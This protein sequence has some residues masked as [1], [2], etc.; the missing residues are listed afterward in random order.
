MV[1]GGIK[2]FFILPRS[3]SVHPEIEKS[4][5]WNYFANSMDN[6]FWFFGESLAAY[7]TIIP[8]YFSNFTTSP[9]LIG[10]I[11]AIR[12][13]GWFLPQLFLAPFVERLDRKMPTLTRLALLERLPFLALAVAALWLPTLEKNL[14]VIIFLG[15]WIW[16]SISSGFTALPWQELIAKVIP[17]SHR[18]RYFGFANLIGSFT[19]VVGASLAGVILSR[20]LYPRNYALSF[21]LAFIGVMISYFFLL[22]NRE[23]AIKENIELVTRSKPYKGKITKVLAED[24]NFR[25]FLISRSLNYFGWMAYGFIAVFAITHFNLPPAYS[26]RFAAIISATSIFGYL[27]WGIA[28]DR[29]GHKRV[30]L[31]ADLIWAIGLAILFL[32]P[33]ITTVYLVFSLIG[34]ATTGDVVGDLN[35]AMEFGQIEDRPTYIGMARTLTSPI[36]LLAPIV[37]GLI[38]KVYDYHIMVGASLVFALLGVIFLGTQVIEPRH[39]SKS[40]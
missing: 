7:N 27:V 8:V 36:L 22:Q 25:T 20:I 2:R 30:V 32:S 21:S 12:D 5:K 19:R 34:F 10:L 16:K 29:Y 6:I 13:T 37:G 33:S 3:I 4:F 23:P 26:A 15:I 31:F 14:A 18:G 9:L 17:V 40:T 1:H 38:V 24:K 11:P 35:L 39:L 28:G